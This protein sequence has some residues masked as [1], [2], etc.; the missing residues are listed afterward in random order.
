MKRCINTWNVKL[1]YLNII[2][3]IIT[4]V[5]CDNIKHQ[6]I[7]GLVYE[8]LKPWTRLGPG[9]GGAT[10]IPTFSYE[11]INNFFIRCDMTGAYMTNDGGKSYQQI[12][13]PN[14]SYSFAF[15][16][17]DSKTMYIGS[18]SLNK[19]SD[20]GET[21]ERIF[22]FKENI[23][24]EKFSGDHAD[25]NLITNEKSL[26]SSTSNQKEKLATHG[27]QS[28]VKNIKVD[29]NNSKTIY[30]SIN[31]YFFYTIDGGASWSKLAYNDTIDYIYTNK[32]NAKEKIYVFTSSN[33]NIIDK[34][35][36]QTITIDYPEQMKPAFSISGGV[37]KE[38]GNAI[39][40]GLHNDELN[41]DYG[42]NS[43]STLWTSKD[44]GATWIQN[45]TSIIVNNQ[46]TLPT[47][48]SLATAEYDAKN[49]YLITRN[50]PEKMENGNIS[51]WVGTIKSSNGG[52]TWKWVW[53]SGGGLG[54]YGISDG[55]D[56]ANIKDAW[57][58]KAFG[59]SYIRMIDVGVA[60]NNG[61]NAIITDWYRSMKTEDGGN[62]WSAIYSTE[63]VDGSYTT[64][65]IDV[66]T[67]YGVHFD[68]FDSKHIS[69]SYT[70]IGFHHSYDGGKSWFRSTQG[71]PSEWQ[72]TCYWVAYDPKVKNK[73]WSVWSGIH[74]FPRGKMTRNPNWS[75]NG[76]GGVAVSYD[77]GKSWTPTVKGMGFDSPSTSIV[78]DTNSPEDNRT[79]YVAA[80]GKGVFKS[81]DGGKS[82]KIHNNG[83]G[84]NLSAFELT[85]QQDGTLF[86]VVSPTPQHKNGKAGRE[87]FM[88]AVYKSIDG[89]ISWQ[90]LRVGDK[91]KFPNGIAF[92]ATN[93]KRIY[94]GSWSDISL[95][96]MV[97][98]S[99]T[100]VTGGNQL[101]DLDGGIMM[102]DDGGNSWT[103]I[104][105]KDKYVYDVTVD[106]LQPGRIY[107]NTFNQGA[108]RSDDYGKSWNKI[109]GYN[110]HWGHR[111]IIDEN[112]PDMVYLTTFGSSVWHGK[113]EID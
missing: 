3:V 34:N 67:T 95:S 91:T 38:T 8:D 37:I 100:K 33:V 112:N 28:T 29:S 82:W 86:L 107:C 106:A 99:V 23:I 9:G 62:T 43:P 31:N 64:N 12:N 19:S 88:G 94:L 25:F 4:T 87:V 98:T 57:A 30:F 97:G 1:T 70:D 80:Y 52:K 40:Y 66:T 36:W 102:S 39:F 104:F 44:F 65:G 81:V 17:E 42:G 101:M 75:K 46:N 13:Y 79:L 51:N 76:K 45:E 18:R 32:T 77:G 10:Y 110:F 73:V 60:P 41:K 84:S 72:N 47:Y 105:D 74:D 58:H 68:P 55:V 103:Q 11:D 63:Q 6:E 20:G 109:K 113:P 48:S 27:K 26:Y 96:D 5:S 24:E 22:P 7:D 49:V 111:V 54:K 83:L 59:K 35:T 90:M 53:K 108:F 50:Y 92:D 93:P 85:I 78:I 16:P 21:W 69:I 14:G 71:I 56:A 2:C 15:D 61:D 89:A